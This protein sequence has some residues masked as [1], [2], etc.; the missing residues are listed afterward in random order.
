MLYATHQE[1]SN[2]K[3]FNGSVG[4]GLR[5]GRGDKDDVGEDDRPL[6][7]KLLR[8]GQLQ[9]G[10]KEGTALEEGDQVGLGGRG[11]FR[12]L[13]VPLERVEREGSAEETGIVAVCARMFSLMEERGRRATHK[14]RH[15]YT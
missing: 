6:S 12:H 8:Q 4:K 14:Q 1:P 15:P 7:T 11:S 10:T 2:H 5:K 3:D 9:T 13:E